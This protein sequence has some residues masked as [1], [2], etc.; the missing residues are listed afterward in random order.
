MYHLIRQRWTGKKVLIGTGVEARPTYGRQAANKFIL[1]FVLTQKKQ[2]VKTAKFLLKMILC[3]YFLLDKKVPK[4]QDYKTF[5]KNEFRF[6]K[7]NDKYASDT[8][9]RLFTFHFIHFFYAKLLMSF[10]RKQAIYLMSQKKF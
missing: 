3:T 5:A 2:K 8:S 1:S 6:I 9:I 4:N 10:N 7:T